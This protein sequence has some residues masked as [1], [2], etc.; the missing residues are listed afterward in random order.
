MPHKITSMRHSIFFVIFLAPLLAILAASVTS[1]ADAADP[2]GVV[3]KGESGPGAGKHIVMLAGDH[4]YRSEESLPALGRILAKHYGFTCTVLFTVN[5]ESGEI[6]PGSS[7]IRG[8]EALDSADLAV[9]FLRFQDFPDNEMKHFDTY[10]RQGKPVVGLRTST[11]A[12]NMPADRT[13]AKYSYRFSGDDF[14]LGFGRQILGETWVAHYGGNHTT[15]ARFIMESDQASHPVL[16]G[17]KDV[18]VQSGAY[19]AHP[20]EGSV[21][22]A[23]SQVI[24][25]MTPDGP[26]VDGKELMPAA[27]VRNYHGDA[28]NEGRVFCSTH[29]ASED[30][31]NDGFRR[32]VVNACL[33]ALGMEDSI[34][35]DGEI[36][37]VGPYHPV[38][39]NFEGYRR[40]VKPEELSG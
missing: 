20:I 27:W 36:G 7:Y 14:K 9:V 40:G 5:K 21:V 8:M 28:G 38:T 4:E 10:I 3:Y 31:L 1:R 35:P 19:E 2:T 13:Y 15:S 29:G 39:F 26:P 30:I 16:R 25:G 18:W 11:H 32:M 12:F 6:E 22:L 33:W 23:K 34:E 37:F 24:K 17:V